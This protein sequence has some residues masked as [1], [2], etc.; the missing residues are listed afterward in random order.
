MSAP[1]PF[2]TGDRV[3]WTVYQNVRGP[4]TWPQYMG[5][6][7]TGTVEAVE[8]KSVRVKIDESGRTVALSR[9]ILS[10]LTSC[11]S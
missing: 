9:S 5:V 3:R 4:D 1:Q 2:H 8:E 6:N 7:H 11:P 10:I